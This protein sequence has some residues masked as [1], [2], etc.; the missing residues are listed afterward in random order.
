MSISASPASATADTALFDATRR[1]L[2]PGWTLRPS[3]HPPMSATIR[4]RYGHHVE[5]NGIY[6]G[7]I[8]A[9]AHLP[10]RERSTFSA[11]PDA[12]TA[13][14]YGIAL[15][16]LITGNFV[17]AHNAVC[18]VRHF[19]AAVNTALGGRERTTFWEFG[20]LHTAWALPDGGR[21]RV[22]ARRAPLDNSPEDTEE[23]GEGIEATTTFNDL[24]F[25]QAA[26]V[27]AV[28]DLANDDERRHV[29][30]CGYPARRLK[31]A[32]PALRGIDTYHWP[33]LGGHFTVSL[34]VDDRVKVEIAAPATAPLF[35]VTVYGDTGNQIAAIRAL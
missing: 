6:D 10:N 15:A 30:V 34:T 3:F 17:P 8:Y 33:N 19:H 9:T 5:L 2:G 22:K 13:E 35:N 26:R 14:A 20:T 12:N 18:P 28:L 16:K 21:A 32:A 29:P 24:T 7:L 1:T 27:L 23:S 11:R 4:S 31:A 25:E